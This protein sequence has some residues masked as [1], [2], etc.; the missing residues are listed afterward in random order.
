MPSYRLY[1][2]DERG[3]VFTADDFQALND[4]SAV[5]RARNI[6]KGR[7]SVFEVWQ[8]TRL[9]YREPERAG[10]TNDKPE[11]LSRSLRTS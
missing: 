9:V 6:A 4:P 7:S 10:V 1:Y 3:E 2:C 8:E 5:D 11:N